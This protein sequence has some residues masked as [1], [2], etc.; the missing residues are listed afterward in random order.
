MAS[1]I[2]HQLAEQFW[3]VN[4]VTSAFGVR[5]ANISNRDRHHKSSHIGKSPYSGINISAWRQNDSWRSSEKIEDVLLSAR[6]SHVETSVTCCDLCTRRCVALRFGE[7]VCSMSCVG[8]WCWE[9]TETPSLQNAC[10]VAG[11]KHSSCGGCGNT[12]LNNPIINKYFGRH[13]LYIISYFKKCV[14]DTHYI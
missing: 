5:I 1:F 7:T 11:I 8:K 9:L 2:V 6:V 10:W 14:S 3:S 4:L 12:I 13:L